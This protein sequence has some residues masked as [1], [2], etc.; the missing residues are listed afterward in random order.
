MFLIK[1]FLVTKSDST[2]AW[3]VKN[4]LHLIF[5]SKAVKLFDSKVSRKVQK[6]VCISSNL[7]TITSYLNVQGRFTSYL[8]CNK[9]SIYEWVSL[10]KQVAFE[11]DS[12]SI[13]WKHHS[14]HC[15]IQRK[16][17]SNYRLNAIQSSSIFQY[18]DLD[19]QIHFFF[20]IRW[21]CTK[22][23]LD[24]EFCWT[25]HYGNIGCGVFKRGVQNSLK[26]INL[27]AHFLLLTFFDK[28]NF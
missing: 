25:G 16:R 9:S 13:S 2:L 1:T 24:K 7:T 17:L 11:F 3:T 21:I 28:I 5:V 8:I 4:D 23:T 19:Y 12:F 26:N 14:I 22:L 27:G 10:K 20:S 15:P 18:L 6:N